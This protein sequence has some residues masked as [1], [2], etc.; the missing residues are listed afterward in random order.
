[1]AGYVRKFTI[2]YVITNDEGKELAR[3]P[4]GKISQKEI[5]LIDEAN[6][7]FF[8]QNTHNMINIYQE[9]KN[10]KKE[11]EQLS[12]FSVGELKGIK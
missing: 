1:M 3:I 2:D 6:Y 8:E 11:P 7:A 9:K 10:Y 4:L 12:L 5:N